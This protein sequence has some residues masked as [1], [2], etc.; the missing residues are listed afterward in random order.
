MKT[1]HGYFLN[2]GPPSKVSAVEAASDIQAMLADPDAQFVTGVEAVLKG[3]L[4]SRQ[5]WTKF[6]DNSR[7]GRANIYAYFRTPGVGQH[8]FND[9]DVKF[10]REPPRKGKHAPRSFLV[11]NYRTIQFTIAHHP[12]GWLGTA[13]ARREHLNELA[14]SFAPW[15]QDD[16]WDR[17]TDHGKMLAKEKKRLLLWDRNMGV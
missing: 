11:V 9:M 13:D 3:A 5:G 8:H 17:R 1:M 6:R 4:P 15:T 12:P 2:L 16:R 10:N 14:A 7:Q